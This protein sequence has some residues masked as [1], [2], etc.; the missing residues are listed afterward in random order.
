MGAEDEELPQSPEDEHPLE[1]GQGEA[2][3]ELQEESG[4]RA[5]GEDDRT[6]PPARD[7]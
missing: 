3:D 5:R 7:P 1:G 6:D 4:G 2:V